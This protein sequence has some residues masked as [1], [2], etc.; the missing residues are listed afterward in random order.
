[1]NIEIRPGVP[2]LPFKQTSVA[3]RP[4]LSWLRDLINADFA[5]NPRGNELQAADT[6]RPEKRG[7]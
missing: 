7:H 3:H 4:D 2:F 1:V 6:K 5:Q